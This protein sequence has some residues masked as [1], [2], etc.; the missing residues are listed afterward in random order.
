MGSS[1]SSTA[2]WASSRLRT[3]RPVRFLRSGLPNKT[4]QVSRLPYLKSESKLQAGPDGEFL[5][6]SYPE[7]CRRIAKARLRRRQHALLGR[8]VLNHRAG[9]CFSRIR[10]SGDSRSGNRKDSVLCLPGYFSRDPNHGGWPSRHPC[11]RRNPTVDG[12]T[13]P[14]LGTHSWAL[15]NRS[16]LFSFIQSSWREFSHTR[17]QPTRRDA[18]CRVSDSSDFAAAGNPKSHY[19]RY[20]GENSW[21]VRYSRWGSGWIS[22][23][24]R[25]L[26]VAAWTITCGS[27]SACCSCCLILSP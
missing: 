26:R 23:P 3:P 4:H 11:I 15:L 10:R 25:E 21:V 5:T 2:H 18:A 6:A 9:R 27:G 13:R 14:L 7:P 20:L 16:A 1:S 19:V 12:D 8:R 24:H 17:P 22:E